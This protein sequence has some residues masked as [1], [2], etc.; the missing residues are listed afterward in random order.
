[1]RKILSFIFTPLFFIFFGFFLLVF[2]PI[3]IIA[4]NLIGPKTH[5][6]VVALL[7]LCLMRSQLILGATFKFVNFKTL[8]THKPVIIIANHQ[9]MWDIPPLIW[10]YRRNRLKFI[11]KKELAKGIPSISY[12]LKHA[13]S[14][15]ID[16]KNPSESIELIRKFARELNNK[17][18]AV[19]IFPEGSRSR[20]GKV[21]PF[22]T[23]GLKALIEQMPN[24]L[25]VPIAISGTGKIDNHGSFLLNL[26]VK[27]TFT[28]LKPRQINIEC[29]ESELDLIR[30]E[31]VG[32]V[33]Q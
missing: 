31:I 22:K 19:C 18:L 14:V 27:V 32:F 3:Q 8:P 6:K 30:S 2:H 11:A 15:T 25:I 12:N 7:N 33:Q 24:A 26:G 16:R 21:K 23:G 10:K 9:S 28:A 17:K 29:V 5:D 1:M 4:K 20:N 13:G